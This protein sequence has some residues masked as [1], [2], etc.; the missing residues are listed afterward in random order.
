MIKGNI[1]NPIENKKGD[2]CVA[3]PAGKL[4]RLGIDDEQEEKAEDEGDG[5][6][7][8]FLFHFDLFLL[9]SLYF[10]LIKK[11]SFFMVVKRI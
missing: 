6:N 4:K 1:F 8:I 2:I 10:D 5:I 3:L 7:H 11:N 9:T